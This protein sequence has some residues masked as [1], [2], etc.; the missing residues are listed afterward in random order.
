MIGWIVQN[1]GWF[2][3]RMIVTF[4]C[5]WTIQWAV[6]QQGYFIDFKIL[7]VCAVSMIV[8]LRFWMPPNKNKEI[9]RDD[10][11]WGDDA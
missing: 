6:H 4:A 1:I 5:L 8:A 9:N 3:I 10:T 11:P 2:I 7:M